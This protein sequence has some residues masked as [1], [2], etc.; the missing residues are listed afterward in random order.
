MLKSRIKKKNAEKLLGMPSQTG[1]FLLVPKC[2][3]LKAE[4]RSYILIFK[5]PSIFPRHRPS[6]LLFL[7]PRP[8][9]LA[10]NP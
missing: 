1:P 3:N 8:Q 2:N 4:D 5:A 9:F 6:S 7:N 10:A